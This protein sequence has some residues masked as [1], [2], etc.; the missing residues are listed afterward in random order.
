[1]N[2][3]DNWLAAIKFNK[4]EWIPCT[5]SYSPMSM[6][7]YG[8]SLQQLIKKY[9]LIGDRDSGHTKCPLFE[10]KSLVWKEGY[11]EDSWGCV[12]KCVQDGLE[13]FIVRHPLADWDALEN[14]ETIFQ[15]FYEYCFN[16]VK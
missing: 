2:I 10:S 13:G 5:V 14:I 9:H 12:K 3:K 15:C 11:F 6:D 16:K 1:M 7:K 8:Q 4:P